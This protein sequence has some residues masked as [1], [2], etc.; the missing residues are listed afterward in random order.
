MRNIKIKLLHRNTVEINPEEVIVSFDLFGPVDQLPNIPVG[1][2]E[3]ALEESCFWGSQ[4]NEE[5]TR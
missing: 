1:P 3:F 2:Y 5:V 4:P